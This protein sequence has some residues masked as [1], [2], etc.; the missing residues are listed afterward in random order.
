MIENRRWQEVWQGVVGTNLPLQSVQALSH[1]AFDSKISWPFQT[2][3][4]WG[5]YY[6]VM[7]LRHLNF[8]VL[9]LVKSLVSA[10]SVCHKRPTM[11]DSH[12]VHH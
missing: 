11:Y 5:V 2:P 8:L 7:P 1:K 9:E 3:E 10:S 4:F 12:D 6:V